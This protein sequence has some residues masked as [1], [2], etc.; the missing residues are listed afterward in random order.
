MKQL[1]TS[2]LILTLALTFATKTLAVSPT[3]TAKT[4]VSP[5]KA[6]EEQDSVLDKQLNDL[7]DRIAS[8]VAQ[9][10]LSEKRGVMGIV[11][12]SSDTQI[13]LIDLQGDTRFIDVDEFTKFSSP[14]AKGSFGI[15]DI[16]KGTKV[17]VL[18]LYNK[19]SR[20]IMA[21]FVTVASSPLFLSGA[22]GTVDGEN[23]SFILID[24]DGKQTTVDVETVTKTSL[25]EKGEDLAKAGFSK[26]ATGQRAFVVGY[27]DKK[28]P[29]RLVGSRILLFPSIPPN[30]LIKQIT[31]TEQTETPSSTGSGKKLTPLT[32]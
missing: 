13:T 31:P 27:P 29:N 28:E 30:P 26:I 4:T 3:P 32:R 7:K 9:L 25:Y 1:L 20:R 21:R 5:A 14:S 12:E 10:K 2:C 11:T 15:S 8:R 16:T 17:G 23:F 24:D 6:A 22:V 19:Q 18:G